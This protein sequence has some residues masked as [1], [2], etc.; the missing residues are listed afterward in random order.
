[1]AARLYIRFTET[2]VRFILHRRIR[3]T[4]RGTVRRVRR[5]IVF[6]CS[7]NEDIDLWERVFDEMP[8]YFRSYVRTHHIRALL[9]DMYNELTE[10]RDERDEEWQQHINTCGGCTA[11]LGSNH[12]LD[13]ENYGSD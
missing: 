11:C 1:M 10:R 12:D 2:H 7:T 4:V 8:E 13:Y 5:E 6:P 9:V 3:N